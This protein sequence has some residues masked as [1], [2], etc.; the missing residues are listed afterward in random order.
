MGDTKTLNTGGKH[1]P[2]NIDG[3]GTALNTAAYTGTGCRLNED[4]KGPGGTSTT[5]TKSST[6]S[7]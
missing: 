7:S 3:G 4:G 2:G 5:G 6:S 1:D